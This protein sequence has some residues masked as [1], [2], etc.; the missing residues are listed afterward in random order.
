[1]CYNVV[2][3]SSHTIYQLFIFKI[4]LIEITNKYKSEFQILINP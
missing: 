3:I 2:H 4:L 1:M